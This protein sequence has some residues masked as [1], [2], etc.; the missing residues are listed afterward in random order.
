LTA[1][2]ISEMTSL[3]DFRNLQV[4]VDPRTRE[5]VTLDDVAEV[6]LGK[7]E[8]TAITRTNEKPSVGINVF[9]QSGANTAQVSKDVRAELD[10]LNHS[11]ESDTHLIFDQGKYVDRSVKNVGNTRSE[12]HTSELQSR[13]NLVCRLL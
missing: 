1:R 2:V 6:Q 4:A 12:E 10:R 5:E 8:Q 3:K 7:E 9:K 13:E 11:L